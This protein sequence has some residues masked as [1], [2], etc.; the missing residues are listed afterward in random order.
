MARVG[1]LVLLQS[2]ATNVFSVKFSKGVLP[3]TKLLV[4]SEALDCRPARL[5]GIDSPSHP[6]FNLIELAM[7]PRTGLMCVED[8]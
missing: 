6:P 7:S 1:S 5:V 2:R 8:V 3:S 4:R